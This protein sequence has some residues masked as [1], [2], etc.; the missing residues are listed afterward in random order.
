MQVKLQRKEINVELH[1]ETTIK[2][3]G[4]KI[5]LYAWLSHAA[6]QSGVGHCRREAGQLYGTTFGFVHEFSAILAALL[7]QQQSE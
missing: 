5:N 4:Y 2:L 6:L 1:I 7:L 3:Y